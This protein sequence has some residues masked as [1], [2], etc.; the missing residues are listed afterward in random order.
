MGVHAKSFY[1][2]IKKLL[3][4]PP[5]EPIFILRA[6]DKAAEASIESYQIRAESK[7]AV[8]EFL[9]G[10]GEAVTEFRQFKAANPE[11][12]KVPD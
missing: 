4:I 3:A 2:E 5:D 7:G 1:P 11:R 12:M 8:S 9:E 10:V 6:Q